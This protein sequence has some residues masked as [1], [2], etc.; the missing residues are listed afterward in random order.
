M[1]RALFWLFVG[2]MLCSCM[3]L[4][5][6]AG[7]LYSLPLEGP[8]SKEDG[9]DLISLYDTSSDFCKQFGEGIKR[10]TFTFRHTVRPKP[11]MGGKVIEGCYL[12]EDEFVG[13]IFEDG[14]R[15]VLPLQAFKD[16]KVATK[17]QRS[18]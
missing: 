3:T 5:A 13:L 4:P 16:G 18:A 2:S 11:E 10:A 7:V 1:T 15:G 6:R 12:I 9:T 8:T 14:D 17:G